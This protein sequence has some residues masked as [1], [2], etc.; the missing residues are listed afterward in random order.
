MVRLM[1]AVISTGRHPPVWKL[2]G[3][4]VVCKPGKDDSTKL[5]ANH[6]RW[7]LSCSAKVVEKVATE[8][9][10]ELAA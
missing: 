9:W 3:S 6:T 7:L 4:V 5:N 2:A 1:R 8:L 10:S